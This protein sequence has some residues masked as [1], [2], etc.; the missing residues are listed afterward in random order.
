MLA[1]RKVTQFLGHMADLGCSYCKFKAEREPGT[2]GASG[3][4]SYLTS[5]MASKCTMTEVLAQAKD[6]QHAKNL[7][8]ARYIEKK[9][10][11]HGTV[12][13]FD[14]H[15]LTQQLWQ[16]L[17]QCIHFCWEWFIMK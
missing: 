15:T 4:M 13:F 2:T 17:T 16:L 9:N 8:Q 10:G 12:K 11:V 3:K 7:T 1:L 14:C 5:T 6:Y